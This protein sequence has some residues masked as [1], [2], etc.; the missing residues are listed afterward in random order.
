M[1]PTPQ[2]CL[3]MRAVV[4]LAYPSYSCISCPKAPFTVRLVCRWLTSYLRQA[5]TCWPPELRFLLPRSL[6]AVMS[7]VMSS[8]NPPSLCLPHRRFFVANRCA[9]TSPAC[10]VERKVDVSSWASWL[11]ASSCKNLYSSRDIHYDCFSM[12]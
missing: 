7:C 6:F 11:I 4:E 3:L 10:L 1:L 5:R 8:S 12:R 2:R 9:L